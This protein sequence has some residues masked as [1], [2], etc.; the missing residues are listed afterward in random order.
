MSSQSWDLFLERSQTSTLL[1]EGRCLS[2]LRFPFLHQQRQRI[3]ELNLSRIISSNLQELLRILVDPLPRLKV[4]VIKCR[5]V[6]GGPLPQLPDNFICAVLPNLQELRLTGVKWQLACDSEAPSLQHFVYRRPQSTRSIS[7]DATDIPATVKAL[8]RMPALQTL[9]LGATSPLEQSSDSEP[10]STTYREIALLHR[11]KE[12]YLRGS[13]ASCW[14]ILAGI[15][16]PPSAQ[17][18]VRCRDCANMEHIASTLQ[19]HLAA[20]STV[21]ALSLQ[22][23]TDSLALHGPEFLSLRF[24][25][26]SETD[27]VGDRPIHD[28]PCFDAQFT[29]RLHDTVRKIMRSLLSLP[30]NESIVDLTLD[31]KRF[32]AGEYKDFRGMFLPMRAV[33]HLRLVRDAAPLVCAAL[34]SDESLDNITPFAPQGTVLFPALTELHLKN[35]AFD[36]KHSSE[37]H[38]ALERVLKGRSD[39][40]RTSL[41]K[42]VLESC[43]AWEEHADRWKT[44][45][46]E[47]VCE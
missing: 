45:A 32:R 28:R 10:T 34:V 7:G 40:A 35:V 25:G 21:Q 18:I 3:R 1:I 41:Q 5:P 4:L 27:N 46:V 43:K 9:R 31:I 24:Y 47:L 29:V 23:H 12:V 13:S 44:Y 15:D 16:L 20:R 37:L 17:I 33:T 8:G 19:A 42:L 14:S 36:A 39:G 38:L 30:F 2:T 26:A 22:H 11:L 6:R